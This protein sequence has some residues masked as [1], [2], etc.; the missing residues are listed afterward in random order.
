MNN[1]ETWYP[2]GQLKRKSELNSSESEL[3]SL[4]DLSE[5]D[6]LATTG[7]NPGDSP[8]GVETELAFRDFSSLSS[9]SRDE[10]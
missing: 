7:V 6:L 5:G 9:D 3:A 4:C 1:Y 8:A 2:R 10:R